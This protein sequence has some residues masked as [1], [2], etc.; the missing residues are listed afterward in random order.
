MVDDTIA[1]YWVGIALGF[2]IGF[3]AAMALRGIL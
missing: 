2:V 1:A 3:S